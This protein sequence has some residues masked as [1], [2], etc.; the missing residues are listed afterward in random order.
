MSFNLSAFCGIIYS[1]IGSNNFTGRIPDYFRSWKNLRALEMQA[2][3]LEGPLPSS[4][5]TLNNMT[6]LRISD[7]SGE[8]SALPNLSSMTGINK[9][10]LTVLPIHSTRPSSTHP[11][12]GLRLLDFSTKS[13]TGRGSRSDRQTLETQEQKQLCVHHPPK[14]RSSSV[15]ITLETVGGI[16]AA[17][18]SFINNQKTIQNRLLSESVHSDSYWDVHAFNILSLHQKVSIIPRS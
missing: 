2:S 4:L 12:F 7:L 17:I 6:D 14:N 11:L 18:K 5:S 8:S 1:Q 13:L 9:F 16:C 15:G 10:R 3:D